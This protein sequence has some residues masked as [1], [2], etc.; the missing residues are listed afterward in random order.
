MVENTVILEHPE[1]CQ[2][3]IMSGPR[4]LR[5]SPAQDGIKAQYVQ[6]GVQND[7]K[8]FEGVDGDDVMDGIYD[9]KVHGSLTADLLHQIVP[10]FVYFKVNNERD[11]EVNNQIAIIH[12]RL[13][14]LADTVSNLKRWGQGNGL[15]IPELTKAYIESYT[16]G[17]ELVSQYFR[18]LTAKVKI[19]K[20]D[21][22]EV[23]VEDASSAMEALNIGDDAWEDEGGQNKLEKGVCPLHTYNNL[24]NNDT[25]AND[26][27]VRTSSPK[28]FS[29]IK[30]HNKFGRQTRHANYQRLGIQGL[31]LKCAHSDHYA[32]GC[33]V[34]RNS[35]YCDSC[36]KVGHV[37]KVCVQSLTKR[38]SPGPPNH[39]K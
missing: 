36:N 32:P 4:E 18:K 39:T 2:K 3:T 17:Q 33:P 7:C 9:S 8:F 21:P 28:N 38:K 37:S 30:K 34:D 15:I 6:P 22:I 24:V 20:K 10:Q 26:S 19:V 27:L 16:E 35:L 14:K 12:E 25:P 29:S 31:C 13:S 11:T 5:P 1:N 23:N